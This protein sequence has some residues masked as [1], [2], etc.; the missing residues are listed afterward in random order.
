MII[1]K[2]PKGD[3]IKVDGEISLILNQ[4]GFLPKYIDNNYVYYIRNMDIL[5][6]MEI[7]NLTEKK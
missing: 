4:N 2:T 7:N 5:K 3:Y 1:R 6:F